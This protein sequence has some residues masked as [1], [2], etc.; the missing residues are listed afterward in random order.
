M[1]RLLW[2]SFLFFSKWTA[3][4]CALRMRF[5][6][7]SGIAGNRFAALRV[8]LTF[9]PVIGF[10]NGMAYW[11]LR[12]VPMLLRLCPSLA[13]LIMKA[14]T[15]SGSYLH[16]LGGRLLTGRIEWDFPFSCL[17]ICTP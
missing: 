10:T 16:Q 3:M 5:A 4:R 1:L 2:A 17:G 7:S 14:S 12:T 15:S 13:S 9:L 11:S 6:R 8:S